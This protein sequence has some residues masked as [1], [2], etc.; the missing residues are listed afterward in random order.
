MAVQLPYQAVI[1]PVRM[2]S[3][4]HLLKFVSVLDDKS[5]FFSLL[6]L[7]RRCC[8]S[9]LLVFRPTIVVCSANLMI[10]FEACMATQSWV[11]REYRRVLRTHTCGAPVLRISG[12]EMLFPTFTT[13]G[14][15]FR[16]SRTQLH[17]DLV[18]NQ[19]LEIIDEFGGYYGV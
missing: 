10:E 13:W 12:L 4:V 8:A 17:R 6:R 2:L 7:K 1:Q 19:G 16:K 5:N 9:L 3:I 14:R 15:P 18:E 11:N